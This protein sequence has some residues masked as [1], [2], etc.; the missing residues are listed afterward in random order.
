MYLRLSVAA[1]F[2]VAAS[3]LQAEEPKFR[4]LFDG[5]SLAGWHKIGGGEWK[6][7]DGE[8][9]GKNVASQPKH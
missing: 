8:I 6:V 5:K 2:L 4:P 7:V 3:T 1:L 9:H